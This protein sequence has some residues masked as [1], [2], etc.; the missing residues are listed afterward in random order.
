L[1]TPSIPLPSSRYPSD[2]NQNGSTSRHGK[3]QNEQ[4]YLP[5]PLTQASFGMTQGG[6]LSQ[7]PF[8]QASLTQSFSQL[9]TQDNFHNGGISQDNSFNYDQEFKSQ[10]S[11]NGNNYNGYY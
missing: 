11:Q 10:A 1:P 8:T 3:K 9:S 5:G 6:P 2:V 4:Q 7:G